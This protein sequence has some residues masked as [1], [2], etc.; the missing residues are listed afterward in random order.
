MITV[1][2]VGFI[3]FIYIYL[4]QRFFFQKR[5]AYFR[6][7]GIV[8]VYFQCL[9]LSHNTITRLLLLGG[10]GFIASSSAGWWDGG[11]HTNHPKIYPNLTEAHGL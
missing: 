3:L 6:T 5:E 7:P 11:I 4:Y 9:Y 1:F 2:M 8:L 10:E